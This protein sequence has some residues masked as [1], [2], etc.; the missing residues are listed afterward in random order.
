[1]LQEIYVPILNVDNKIYIFDF[2]KDYVYKYDNEGKYLGKKEVT[3]KKIDL[4]SGNV[5]ATYILDDH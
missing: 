2:Q 1:M 3:L 4:E 5:I